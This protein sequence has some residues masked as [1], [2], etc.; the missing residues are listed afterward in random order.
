MSNLLTKGQLK[1][2]SMWSSSV[3]DMYDQLAICILNNNFIYKKDYAWLLK[4]SKHDK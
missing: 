3:Y 4:T 2:N 1:G